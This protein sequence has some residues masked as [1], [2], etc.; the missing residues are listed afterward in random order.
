MKVGMKWEDWHVKWE[1]LKLDFGST[2]PINLF[3]L[4]LFTRPP[5]LC[6]CL[7][8]DASYVVPKGKY[9]AAKVQGAEGEDNWI[10][11]EVVLFNHNTGKYDVDDIDSE[12]GRE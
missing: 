10:L 1:N 8:A 11:A 5:Q 4:D 12:E 7:Q 3:L 6:G 9:V 2:D